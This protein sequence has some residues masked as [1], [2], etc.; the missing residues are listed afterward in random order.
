MAGFLGGWTQHLTRGV[1]SRPPASILELNRS[2]RTTVFIV[3]GDPH[4]RLDVARHFHERS[5]MRVAPLVALDCS[6]QELLLT[7]ALTA[8][9]GG[10][11]EAPC[12]IG[13]RHCGTLF[14]DRIHALSMPA[15][16]LLSELINRM[17]QPWWKNDSSTWW[18]RLVAGTEVDLEAI[19]AEGAFSA[20]LLDGLDKVRVEIPSTG[21]LQLQ[22]RGFGAA[23]DR[24]P[25][26]PERQDGPFGGRPIRAPERGLAH[27]A[28]PR[29]L[30]VAPDGAGSLISRDAPVAAR[31]APESAAIR[32]A[33]ARS[34]CNR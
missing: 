17:G 31:P 20:P 9:L 4:Q 28:I 12:A 33:P 19:V 25:P 34:A 3:G 5:P 26:S 16:R 7:S 21:A 8:W 22:S 1:G 14:V 10:S 24:R 11:V 2:S 15:Q 23:E 32:R 6:R 13:I 30:S 29:L 27:S 18:G